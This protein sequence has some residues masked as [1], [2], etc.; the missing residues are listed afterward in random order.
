MRDDPFDERDGLRVNPSTV[1]AIGDIIDVRLSRRALLKGIGAG[2]AFGLFG[3][4]TLASAPA[5]DGS[6]PLTFTEIGRTTDEKHHL[7]SGYDAQVLIAQGDPIHRGAP[8][9][10]PGA[11]TGDDQ[12]RQ[13][14]TDAD[15]IAYMPLP[16]GSNSSTRGLLGVN[17][18]NHRAVLCFPGVKNL[19]DLT[20]EQ[21]EVQM[22]AQGFSLVEIAREGNRWRVVVESP[23]NRRISTNA[24]MRISG[25][26]AG[27]AR[28][29]TPSDPSGTKVFGTFNN[30]AGGTTPWGTILTAEENFQNYFV[31]T[32]AQ[33]PEAASRK[34]Y[35]I[36][37]RGR[38]EA[39]GRHFARFNLDK[40]PNEPNRFGWIVEI[41]PYD[42][43][44]MPVKRTALGRGAHECATQAVSHDGRVA[45]YS[46]DDAR[47]EYVYKFV[48]RDRFDPSRPRENRDLLDNGT[49]YVARFE[50]NGKMHWL[51]LVY[52]EGP[53]VAANGF[54]S[55]ADVMIDARRAG[56]L[57]KAT[58][59]DRPED[60]EAHP[61][62]GRVYV[63]LTYNES[64]KPDQVDAANPRAN[65]RFGHII[66][67]VP[68]LVNGKPD[69]AATECD[70][71]FFMLG[72][73]PNDPAHGARYANPVTANGWVAAPDNVAFDPKGRVWIS[74]DGQDD[75]AG[76]ND[77]L[78]AACTT[79]PA[80]GATRCFFNGPRGSEICG[81]A[82]TPDG[83]TLF[84]AVQHPGDEKGSTFEKPSTRWPDF[85]PDMPPRSA[86]V[87]ITRSDGGEIGG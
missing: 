50:A 71:G 84:L 45:F 55:Q 63:V 34:R 74:T 44:S 58:P 24:E 8:A 70:W 73:N 85:K 79:G 83:K 86:V 49:L 65:N 43:Q 14:G 7:A 26:A 46:G 9:Y 18:E 12:E 81:P 67:I 5:A 76:F 57:L 36:A 48:T 15:F 21:C 27:H 69:H 33:G 53:L 78:Y 29:Q 82:F 77:S 25:P 19:A 42:P 22:A 51:P 38:Y 37:G 54:N 10:R 20:R 30:C 68:P 1:P 61:L 52:G 35:N 41:D 3:C 66:E 59:M 75:S 56:D 2:G 31:G 28:M 87:A 60:V 62:T 23:F 40:E 13:F 16:R 11:Q 64:R 39:W 72:G 17:H 4:A 80:R 32:A 6:A 47:M